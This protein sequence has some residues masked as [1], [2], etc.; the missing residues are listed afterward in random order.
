VPI[1]KAF[2]ASNLGK[3]R[4]KRNVNSAAARTLETTQVLVSLAIVATIAW[5]HGRKAFLAW[6][7]L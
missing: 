7:L 6:L 2:F 4:S 5:R 3:T 1:L